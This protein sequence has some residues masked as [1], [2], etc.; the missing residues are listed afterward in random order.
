ML[1]LRADAVNQL[2]ALAR[3]YDAQIANSG[4][5]RFDDDTTSP[6]ATGAE[7]LIGTPLLADH[8]INGLDALPE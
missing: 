1:T 6:A 2:I 4:E 7:Y 5:D 3:D 8:W